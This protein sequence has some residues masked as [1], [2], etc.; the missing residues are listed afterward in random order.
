MSISTLMA[1]PAAAGLFRQAVTQS[2]A[3]S[4]LLGESVARRVTRTL[5]ESLGVEPTVDGFA[6]VDLDKFVTEQARFTAAVAVDRNP[7]T[8]G[9]L[10]LNSMPFEPT[11]DGEVVPGPP[12]EL[13]RSGAGSGVR[14]LT[15][16][17]RDEMTL[18][19]APTGLVERGDE[20]D[21]EIM[22]GFYGLS[23][24]AVN[25]YRRERPEAVPGEL[26]IDVVTDWV[27]RIPAI[28]VAEARV[29][30]AAEAGVTLE[31]GAEPTY[32]YEFGWRTLVGRAAWG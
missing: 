1:M 23:V 18:F 22:A 30:A 26:I 27:F 13:I 31:M 8:W 20:A 21:L 29:E 17:N 3:A 6:S 5:A 19:L 24:D 11:I 9:E 28:R 15:G 14:V 25:V 12:L 16:T 10:V 4:H 7:A 2:G 32:V